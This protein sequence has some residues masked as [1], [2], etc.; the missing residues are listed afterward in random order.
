M[1]LI[2]LNAHWAL[3]VYPVFNNQIRENCVKLSYKIYSI[4]SPELQLIEMNIKFRIILFD[5]LI[6]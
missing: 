3:P 4:L 5:Q 2:K 6:D 1:F